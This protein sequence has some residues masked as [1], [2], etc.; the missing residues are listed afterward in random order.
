MTRAKLE[1][2]LP[3]HK[4]H[5]TCQRMC[6]TCCSF[7]PNLQQSLCTKD[8]LPQLAKSTPNFWQMSAN[9][10]ER[11]LQI[12]GNASQSI[13]AVKLFPKV[14]CDYRELL[15]VPYSFKKIFYATFLIS[16]AVIMHARLWYY[17]KRKH[18]KFIFLNILSSHLRSIQVN[19]VSNGYILKLIVA[20]LWLSG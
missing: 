14:K 2:R 10:G 11:L 9:T 5:H 19:C 15:H 18:G 4:Q 12:C 7:V 8:S 1:N 17:A 6:T 16:C 20:F 13:S 3:G